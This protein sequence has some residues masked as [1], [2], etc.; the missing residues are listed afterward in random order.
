MADGDE[1]VE[2]DVRDAMNRLAHALDQILNGKDVLI[3]QQRKNGFVLLLFPYDD[4][5]G[6]C[7]YVSNGADRKDI[8]KICE[9]LIERFKGNGSDAS[10]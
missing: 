1:P 7:N 8:I 3:T 10:A 9:T 2:I 6:R 5:S 4:E